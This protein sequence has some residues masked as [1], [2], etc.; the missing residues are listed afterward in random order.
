VAL[1]G[2]SIEN[3][4]RVGLEAMAAGVPIVADNR[5]GWREMIEDGHSGFLC[6]TLDEAAFRIANLAYDEQ[7]RMGVVIAGRNRVESLSA[8]EPI[9][10]R[11]YKLLA[12]LGYEPG[13]STAPNSAFAGTA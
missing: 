7:L 10:L 5:G 13:G 6:D 1:N 2:Q 4:P 11:W 3:W 12:G 8:P 9:W